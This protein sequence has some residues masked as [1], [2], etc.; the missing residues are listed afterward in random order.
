MHCEQVYEAIMRHVDWSIVKC[1]VIAGPGFTKDEFRSF[2]DAEAVRR[3]DRALLLNKARVVLAPASSAFKHCLK[4]VL[5][6]PAVASQIKVCVCVQKGYN[7]G[8]RFFLHEWWWSSC[9]FSLQHHVHVVCGVFGPPV[10][11]AQDTK[12]AQETAALQAFH[13]MMATEP[14]RAFYGPGHVKAAHEVGAIQVWGVCCP[15]THA[16]KFILSRRC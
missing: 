10:S 7:A 1:L 3:D 13:T 15:H 11:N 12:A 16:C 5:A 4:E 9:L 2:L 8:I 14:A 6:L